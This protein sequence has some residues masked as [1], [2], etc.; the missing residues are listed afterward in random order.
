[1]LRPGS[2]ITL[3]PKSFAG[4]T[5]ALWPGAAYG[6]MTW[7]VGIRVPQTE[8]ITPAPIRRN[9]A[10]VERQVVKAGGQKGSFSHNLG[11]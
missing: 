5:H 3:L 7:R 4:L 2:K 1:M 9:R 11:F 6:S 10:V 8:R